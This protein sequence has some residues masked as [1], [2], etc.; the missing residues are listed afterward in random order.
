MAYSA[1]FLK[2]IITTYNRREA[3]DS[4]WGKDGSGVEWEPAGT[5]HANVGYQKGV[6]GMNAG[7]LDVYMVKIVRMRWNN[8][9]NARS[10]VV[11][12]GKTY[13]IIAET[14]NPNREADELQFLIQEKNTSE[15]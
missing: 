10:R 8:V 12:D 7:S 4:K 9:I 3:V 14:F 6:G 5:F 1:G 13:Q 11:F 2:D 15:R